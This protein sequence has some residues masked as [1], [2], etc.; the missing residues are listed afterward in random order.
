MLREALAGRRA[1]LGPKHPSTLS[2][3]HI[4]AILLHAQGKLGESEALFKETLEGLRAALGPRH[5]D[6]LTVERWLAQVSQQRKMGGR[7]NY[8]EPRFLHMSQTLQQLPFP[9]VRAHIFR[10]SRPRAAYFPG[11]YKRGERKRSL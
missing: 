10:L 3:M 7:R 4:F 11:L 1:T 9:T 6:S 8:D 5:P 2:S